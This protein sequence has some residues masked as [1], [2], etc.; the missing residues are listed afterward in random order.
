MGNPILAYR[1]GLGFRRIFSSMESQK[2][3]AKDTEIMAGLCSV[4]L[5]I[6]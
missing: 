6:P 3:N 2:E 5:G 1:A 4:Y